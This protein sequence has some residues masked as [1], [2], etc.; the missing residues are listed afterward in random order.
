MRASVEIFVDGGTSVI[1]AN[2][3][4]FFEGGDR[5]AIL[6][7]RSVVLTFVYFLLIII[8]SRRILAGVL[9]PRTLEPQSALGH[10]RSTEKF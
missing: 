5:L 1:R 9:R 3:F 2:T 4:V 6:A 10:S 8:I 7:L